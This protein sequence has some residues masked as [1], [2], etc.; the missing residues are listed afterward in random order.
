MGQDIRE[1]LQEKTENSPK[2]TKGHESRFEERLIKAF[3]EEQEEARTTNKVPWLK[4]G[5]AAI[6]VVALGVFGILKSQKGTI[7]NENSIVDAK[8]KVIESKKPMTLADISP[9]LQEIENFY[10]TG[11]NLQ[12][13][14]LEY[15]EEHQEL[16]DGYMQRL[17]D[18][19]EAYEQL[20]IELVQVGPTEAAVVA[21]MENLK[22]KLELL[23]KLKDK[24]K[25][26]KLQ[27]NE[28][29][30]SIQS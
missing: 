18:L 24:L 14:S 27:N 23:V 8:E 30:N 3:H 6:L 12:L 11:I 16:I 28:Q 9:D 2:L 25:E 7:T 26:L 10:L 5:V 19:D 17:E 1:L 22:L 29:F 15:S 20:K 4:L 21:L 13:A